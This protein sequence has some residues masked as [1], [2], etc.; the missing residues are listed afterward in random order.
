MPK[1]A[2]AK[3]ELPPALR[4]LGS[5]EG[6]PSLPGIPARDLEPADLVR[7]AGSP[8]VQRRYAVSASSLADRLIASGIY[9]AASSAASEKPAATKE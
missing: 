5:D 3:P 7:L 4:Y 1:R 2:P 8:F 6:I 9:Q